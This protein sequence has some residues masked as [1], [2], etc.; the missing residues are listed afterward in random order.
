L[1]AAGV[2]PRPAV[3][4]ALL[5]VRDV[6][7]RQV[8]AQEVA[9]VCGA[10]Q[11]AGFRLDGF[12]DAIPDAGSVDAEISAVGIELQHIGAVDLG[13]IIVR[14]VD[15]GARAHGNEYFFGIGGKDDIARSVAAAIG[16]GGIA[17]GQS[18][19]DYFRRAAGL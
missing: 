19:H 9:F 8:I 16:V 14:V 2:I 18:L 4:A 6:I 15:V 5:D 11:V 3:K 1:M 7:G 13:G 10:P 12:A 17:A